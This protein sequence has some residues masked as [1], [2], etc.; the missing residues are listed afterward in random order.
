MYPL[1][2][3]FSFNQNGVL[4]N[5]CNAPKDSAG[6]YIIFHKEEIIYIGRSGRIDNGGKVKIRK[7]GL[8]ERIVNGTQFKQK[9]HISLPIKMK[10]EG[11]GFLKIYWLVTH[12]KEKTYKD[13]T[14]YVEVYLLNEYLNKHQKL[15]KWNK[16]L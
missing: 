14:A 13:S 5:D 16:E 10:E 6:I 2:D 8:Y 3:H 15:P 7:N 9:R 1:N 12:N 4:K 11:I